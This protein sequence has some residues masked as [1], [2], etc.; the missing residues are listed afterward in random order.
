MF[1]G[2]GSE[3]LADP[4]PCVTGLCAFLQCLFWE[5]W[6]ERDW[7]LQLLFLLLKQWKNRCQVVIDE[8]QGQNLILGKSY[9]I[10]QLF[11]ATFQ[12]T[13]TSSC[14]VK[15]Y[16]HQG[17]NYLLES[18][19]GAGIWKENSF[20]LPQIKK[21]FPQFSDI[22]RACQHAHVDISVGNPAVFQ[23]L[24]GLVF[25]F[26]L[27]FYLL[28]TL[29]P[30]TQIRFYPMNTRWPQIISASVCIKQIPESAAHKDLLNSLS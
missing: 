29:A 17:G 1:N 30:Y 6:G 27:S 20:Q 25:N 9:T 11:Q 2:F 26:F 4:L 19:L 14:Q 22:H 16:H 28:G 15:H 21:K 3:G 8:L 23:F 18:I 7:L 13:T 12:I 24:P 5:V 10:N